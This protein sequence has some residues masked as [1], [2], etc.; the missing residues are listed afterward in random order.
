VEQGEGIWGS[1]P[2][3]QQLYIE[4]QPV[5]RGVGVGTIFVPTARRGVEASKGSGTQI[6]VTTLI[7]SSG[8]RPEVGCGRHVSAGQPL[9][10]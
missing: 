5:R 8:F 9:A 7:A 6:R 1:A 4:L 2:S 3:R 10:H